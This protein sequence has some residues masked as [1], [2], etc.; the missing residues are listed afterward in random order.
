[1]S[2]LAIKAL[3]LTVK[4][5]AKPVSK[6]I[7][8]LAAETENQKF[9]GWCIKAGNLANWATHTINVRLVGGK[10]IKLKP[11]GDAEAVARGGE[12]VGETFV[13]SVAMTMVAIELWRKEKVSMY[14]KEQKAKKKLERRAEKDRL[15]AEKFA[16]FEKEISTL[17]ENVQ[18][19]Q[20]TIKRD[21]LERQTEKVTK[22]KSAKI[23]EN[24]TSSPEEN[25]SWSSWFFPFYV[26]S[27]DPHPTASDPTPYV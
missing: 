25:N 11:L 14:E 24:T 3:S 15:L 6:G 27:V 1:M 23:G 21:E 22:I 26:Q 8:N 2:T 17:R 19:L 12:V 18:V 13:L 9:R 10:K 20:E 16:N 4:A 5:I 7:Q